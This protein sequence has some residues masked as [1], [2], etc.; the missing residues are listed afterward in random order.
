[1]QTDFDAGALLA[2]IE[3]E[4]LQMELDSANTGAVLALFRAIHVLRGTADEFSHHHILAA[5]R[6]VKSV[7][8]EIHAGRL[9]ITPTVDIL[10][11]VL[12]NYLASRTSS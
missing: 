8:T 1:M 2:Q 9:S 10:L 7:L 12:H 3:T 5:A 11:E 6:V 4:L